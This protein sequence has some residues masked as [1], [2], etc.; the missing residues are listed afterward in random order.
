MIREF[1]IMLRKDFRLFARDKRTLVLVTA[2]PLLIMIILSSIFG[3]ETTSISGIKAAVCKYDNNITFDLPV[4]DEIFFQG[5]N[6]EQDVKNLVASGKFR[7]AVVIPENFE[8]DLKEGKGAVIK[9]Y[10]DNSK[11][12]IA[13]VSG[14]AIAAYAQQANE[15][16][17]VE[18]IKQ[19][20]ENIKKL[21]TQLEEVQKR[22]DTAIKYSED[23]QEKI[24]SAMAIAKE[25]EFPVQDIQ[26]L[27]A[28]LDEMMN[29]IASVNLSQPNVEGLR[30][31]SDTISKLPKISSQ[32]GSLSNQ[33]GSVCMNI[34]PECEN[35]NA[36]LE[37]LNETSASFDSSI[38]GLS[39]QL[40]ILINQTVSYSQQVNDTNSSLGSLYENISRI[41]ENLIVFQQRLENLSEAKQV[42]TEKLLGLN[43]TIGNLANDLTSLNVQLNETRN[44]LTNYTS[45]EPQ[46]IIKPITVDKTDVFSKSKYIFFMAPALVC[47]I[48][49]FV[50][51]LISSSNVVYER[52]SGT[53]V[54]NVLSPAPLI[55][56]MLEK[57]LYFVILSLIQVAI[58]LAVLFAF[59]VSI[60]LTLPVVLVFLITSAVFTTI[61]LLIG[62]LSKSENTALLTSLVLAIPML[63]LSGAFFSFEIMPKFMQGVGKVLPLT[64]SIQ[65]IEN[66]IIY[67]TPVLMEDIIYLVAISA[68]FFAIS[69]LLIKKEGVIK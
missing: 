28:R 24:N 56:F 44:I 9:A 58:M 42:Y 6:C 30:N 26:I 59:G 14:N 2:A 18:F 64:V 31:I 8:A 41:R 15:K 17:G 54:R 19:A 65:T 51:T 53:M 38:A 5:A 49:L 69:V 12:Q 27:N 22:L 55:L 34:S 39:E 36:L 57:L 33:I 25:T 37:N 50:I 60:P 62:N 23:A 68:I 40:D 67:N 63:F 13:V 16:I 7:V 35:I 52:K 20:W 29:M 48:L 11:S 43:E 3:S 32:I 4:F 45:K 47:I 46:S 1:L 21:N 61:G 10:L 66:L